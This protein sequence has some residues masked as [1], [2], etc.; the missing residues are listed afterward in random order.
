MGRAVPG[1]A[2]AF[3]DAHSVAEIARSAKGLRPSG[4]LHLEGLNLGA[5][6][7]PVGLDLERFEVFAPAG[8][9]VVHGPEGEAELPLPANAYFRG[10]VIGEPESLAVLTVLADGRVRGIVRRGTEAWEL[11]AGQAPSGGAR[12]LAARRVEPPADLEEDSFECA[13]EELAPP[14]EPLE[15]L[16]AP[17]PSTGASVLEADPQAVFSTSYTARVAVETDWELYERFGT[18]AAVT[19]YVGDLFAYASTVYDREIATDLQV[20]HLSVWTTSADPYSHQG[21]CGLYEF[22]RYWNQNRSGV[23]RTIAHFVS[24]KSQSS[25]V[26]WVGVLCR[27]A[28]AVNIGTS[29]SGL[30]PSIDN[31][32]GDY[33][34]SGGVRGTFNPASPSPVWDI[35][36]V[37]HEIGH[38]FNSPHT[39]C[40]AG[41]GGSSSPVDQCYS[42]E[43]GCYAGTP[44]LP[45]PQ[46]AG[47]GTLMS[48]CHL[49]S[50]GLSNTALTFGTGHPY[51]TLPQ[52][53]PDRMR[54][55][56]ESR[57][58]AV[59][60]CLARVGGGGDGGPCEDLTLSS[61]T[62]RT[63]QEYAA[64]G[65]LRAGAGFA[66]E[67]PGYVTLR[68]GTVVLEDGFSVGAG[69]RLRVESQ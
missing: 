21:T 32:G 42:A 58:A 59:P 65:T 23:G 19:D 25:G 46:G 57:A 17:I 60:A 48:Y 1:A 22:G 10:R 26:A 8:R 41:I 15:P 27:G 55:H 52:R 53:V 14:P 36:V 20:T 54:A 50:G 47:S 64:C 44:S 11:G 61:Q 16:E 43:P 69:A 12:K 38:N 5:D 40:Y 34:F 31:Y 39:H 7:A 2:E 35:V 24:G 49:R 9:V 28:F 66:V 33:G 63:T 6:E 13:A 18:Q 51:G 45:G 4:R 3:V 37:S 62:V 30:T 68:A 29:C 67:S 56:V